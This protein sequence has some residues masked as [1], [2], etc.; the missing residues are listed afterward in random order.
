M[1]GIKSKTVMVVGE[2]HRVLG[3]SAGLEPTYA[4]ILE[5]E[6]YQVINPKNPQEARQIIDSGQPL[7]L[8]ITGWEGSMGLLKHANRLQSGA[9]QTHGTQYVITGKDYDAS[10]P[11]VGKFRDLLQ[12]DGIEAT[13]LQELSAHGLLNIVERLTNKQQPA[14]IERGI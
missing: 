8:I 4:E 3:F 6:G 10:G 12:K 2:Q 5:R 7:D 11:L 13:Y 9:I 1:T 14:S